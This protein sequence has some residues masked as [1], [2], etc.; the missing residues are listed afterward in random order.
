M[1]GKQWMK[2]RRGHIALAALA[3]TILGCVFALPDLANGTEKRYALLLSLT[4]WWSWGYSHT[5]Y[6]LGG[7]ADPRFQQATCPTNSGACPAEPPGDLYAHSLL[8]TQI[9]ASVR[10]CPAA[11]RTIRM[12]QET[13]HIRMPATVVFRDRYK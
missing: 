9:S 12:V 6:S 10:C 2:T 3:W 13:T 5:S 4:L 1:A 7:P 8:P 11:G